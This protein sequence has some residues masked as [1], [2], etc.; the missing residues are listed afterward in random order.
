MLTDL[1]IFIRHVFLWHHVLTDVYIFM[2]VVFLCLYLGTDVCVFVKGAIVC[3]QMYVCMYVSE[4][5]SLGRW[6]GVCGCWYAGLNDGSE[7]SLVTLSAENLD[8]AAWR[9]LPW[10]VSFQFT[11]FVCLLVSVMSI[12]RIGAHVAVMVRVRCACRRLTE[13]FTIC[14]RKGLLLKCMFEEL[15]D[16][17]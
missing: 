11:Y 16:E 3:S 5:G 2:K 8:D 10:N 12:S 1:Y 7:H 13:H 15:S 6:R 4:F 17:T 9:T 14:V